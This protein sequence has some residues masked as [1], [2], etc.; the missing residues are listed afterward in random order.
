[1]TS[2]AVSQRQREIGLRIALGA[3]GRD[4]V[5][6]ILTQQARLAWAGLLLGLAGGYL[7]SRLLVSVLSSRIRPQDPWTFTAMALLLL[8][9]TLVATYLPA[10][11]ALQNRSGHRFSTK[12]EDALK[13]HFERR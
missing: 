7:L 4:V 6:E 1:V 11:K 8:A 2:F 3:Q 12:A 9:V 10:R 13:F 5:L